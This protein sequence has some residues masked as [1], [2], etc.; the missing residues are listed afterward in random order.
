MPSSKGLVRQ[1]TGSAGLTLSSLKPTFMVFAPSVAEADTE[2]SVAKYLVPYTVV[3][4]GPVTTS[5]CARP[6]ASV[7]VR[8][9]L[10]ALRLAVLVRL[11]R[12][13]RPSPGLEV[14]MVKGPAPEAPVLKPVVLSSAGVYVLLIGRMWFS[15]N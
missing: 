3:L 5:V 13:A 9:M 8:V 7:P 14:V 11:T 15:L 1:L 6:S 4:L 2:V 10:M 12:C